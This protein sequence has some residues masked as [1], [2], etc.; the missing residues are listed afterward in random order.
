MKRFMKV[1][2]R[3]SEKLQQQ[4]EQKKLAQHLVYVVSEYVKLLS[5]GVV[6]EQNK[7]MGRSVF[8]AHLK[9]MLA[10]DPRVIEYACEHRF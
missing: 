5:D 1:W 4:Q 2:D 3:W 8:E 7:A 9:K 6:T 10:V